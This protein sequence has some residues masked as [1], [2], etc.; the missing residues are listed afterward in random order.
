MCGDAERADGHWKH[1]I[2]GGGAE[3]TLRSSNQRKEHR[4][5]KVSDT[6]LVFLHPSVHHSET[7]LLKSAW[8]HRRE[9]AGG[10]REKKR[11]KN[12]KNESVGLGEVERRK[13][14]RKKRRCRT[15]SPRHTFI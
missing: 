9:E 3:S 6:I 13:G 4:G 11:K 12:N 10:E 14:G 5:N 1:V 15:S 8:T 7:L 2:L